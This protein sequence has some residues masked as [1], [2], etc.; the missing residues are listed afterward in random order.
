MK[1]KGIRAKQERD[2]FN[3]P[4][5]IAAAIQF[6]N[7]EDAAKAIESFLQLLEERGTSFAPTYVT[8]NLYC[9]LCGAIAIRSN[10]AWKRVLRQLS[11]FGKPDFRPK[12][13]PMFRFLE[14]IHA[15]ESRDWED[16]LRL[17]R[18][19]R[20]SNGLEEVQGIREVL[21]FLATT[22][23]KWSHA[24][25]NDLFRLDNQSREQLLQITDGIDLV[26]YFELPIWLE[27]MQRDCP[28]MDIFHQRANSDLKALD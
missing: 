9:C 17:I 5:S 2:Y 27:A 11:R 7:S 13:Y 22:I 15:I 28:M 1:L 25:G 24:T 12:F 26:D 10:E 21:T 20:S 23:S 14:V 18:N 3:F 16:A 8:E 6:G 4:A 19:L